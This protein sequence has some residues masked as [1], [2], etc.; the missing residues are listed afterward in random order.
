MHIR[1][2]GF[3]LELV[4]CLHDFCPASCGSKC[5]ARSEQ[6]N[7]TYPAAHRALP[8]RPLGTQTLALSGSSAAFRGTLTTRRWA[9]IVS[10]EHTPAPWTA[11]ITF[12]EGNRLHCDRWG[13]CIIALGCNRAGS[14][15][16][17]AR[18]AGWPIQKGL[19]RV[20]AR[21]KHLGAAECLEIIFNAGVQ[22]QSPPNAQNDVPQPTCVAS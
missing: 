1:V 10:A 20:W 15:N 18:D 7:R 4:M 5:P 16:E 13:I 9:W 6:G 17:R 11:D 12:R 22:T 3:G 19:L 2:H 21:A 8:Y 14:R